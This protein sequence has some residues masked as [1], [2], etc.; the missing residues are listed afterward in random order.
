[1]YFYFFSYGSNLL[2][3]RI[4]KRVDTVE[5]I[6]IHKLQGYELKFNKVSIDGSTKANVVPN[7]EA[8]VM[9]VIHRIAS[10]QKPI[11]DAY[12]ALGKGYELQYFELTIAGEVQKIGF[13]QATDPQFLGNGLPYH[14]YRE[15]VRL[16]AIQNEFDADY[17]K[18]IE[19]IGY[20]QDPNKD[21]AEENWEVLRGVRV[22]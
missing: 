12:E 15:Y 18:K 7:P 2:F 14:W 6:Q 1:M 17:V 20:I 5:V 16:G 13:Y 21:R 11:L 3:E 4:H 9:G 22:S 8:Y 19:S 10:E